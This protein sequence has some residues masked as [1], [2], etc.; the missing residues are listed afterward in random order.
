MRVAKVEADN[1]KT[2]NKKKKK[3]NIFV[4]I[5]IVLLVI[6]LFVAGFVVYE[7]SKINFENIDKDSLGVDENL[8]SKLNDKVS[9]DEFK[10]IVNIALFGSDSRNVNDASEGRTDCIMIA[11]VNTVDKTIKLISI[12]RDSYVEVPGYGYTKINHAYSYGGEKLTIETINKNFGLNITDYITINFSG[13]INIVNSIGGIEM[14][15]TKPELDVLNSYLA[16]SYSVSGKKYTP[17]TEYGKVTLNGEQ[18]LAHARDRYVGSDFDRANRQRQ[19]LSAIMKK[20]ST[21]NSLKI[22]D[23][24]TNDF[25]NQVTTNINIS[26]YTGIF[27]KVL[28]GKDT[29]VNNI[30][31]YQVP[32]TEYGY[33]KYINGVYYFC[34]D[35]KKAQD[36]LYNIIYSNK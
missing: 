31:S 36:D 28:A 4:K 1:K 12:P 3:L 20:V 27:L 19:V 18:A 26:K 23:I 35:D 17:M 29:Y 7:L 25:L 14:E 16:E 15:I 10:N 24:V 6:L 8:F 30:E 13:L 5:I 32:S 2:G 34:F 11:S 33:D 22:F 9:E 21:L